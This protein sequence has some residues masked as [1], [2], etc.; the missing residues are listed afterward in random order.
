M[1]L[2]ENSDETLFQETTVR[3][4]LLRL[5]SEVRESGIYVR[6]GPFQ[7]SYRRIRADL[8]EKVNVTPYAATRYAGWHWG[9][10]AT[11][12]GNTVYRLRGGR[13]IEIV[14]ENGS[15]WF[16]GSQRPNE[17]RAAIERIQSR[18]GDE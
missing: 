3:F 10:R 18:A 17:F 15:R 7:R 13:G 2:T 8:I 12:G 16:I 9:R 1:S 4:W 6:L 11:P 14:H 5:V